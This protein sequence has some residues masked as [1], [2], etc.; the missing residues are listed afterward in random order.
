LNDYIEGSKKNTIYH[1]RTFD[2]IIPQHISKKI[3]SNHKDKSR[4]KT[5]RGKPKKDKWSFGGSGNKED[6]NRSSTAGA[7]YPVTSRDSSGFNISPSIANKKVKFNKNFKSYETIERYGLSDNH[8]PDEDLIQKDNTHFKINPSPYKRR[9]RSIDELVQKLQ[10]QIY[11]LEHIEALEIKKH[12]HGIKPKSKTKKKLKK[13]KARSHSPQETTN[14]AQKSIFSMP[15]FKN[16]MPQIIKQNNAKSSKLKKPI[17]KGNAT[18][19]NKYV[20]LELIIIN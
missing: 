11:E 14:P 12:M 1:D 10:N 19:R 6:Q 8:K 7:L 18:S 15:F 3:R 5:P 2:G 20:L 9:E 4:S 13:K 17:Q 16:K